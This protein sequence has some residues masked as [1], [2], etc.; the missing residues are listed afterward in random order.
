MI[1]T[2]AR[3]AHRTRVLVKT[4]HHQKGKTMAT[5][6]QERA[7]AIIDEEHFQ[8]IHSQYGGSSFSAALFDCGYQDMP[9]AFSVYAHFKGLVPHDGSNLDNVARVRIGK[10]MEK[11]IAAETTHQKGWELLTGAHYHDIANAHEDRVFVL[12][13]DPALRMGCTVDCYVKEHEDGPG[14]I[15]CKNRDYLQWLD[16]Y[17]DGHASIRDRIQLSHQFLCHPEIKWGCIAALVGG[18]TLEIYTYKPADLA[19]IMAD[20]EAGWRDMW[21]RVDEGDEPTLTGNELPLWLLAHNEALGVSPAVL[22]LDVDA[23]AGDLPFDKAAQTYVEA[24]SLA[25]TYT[26]AAKEMKAVL[27]QSLQEH[28]RARSNRY[29]VVCKY[30]NIDAAIVTLPENIKVGLRAAS[31]VPELMEADQAH[32]EA[33]LDWSQPTRKASTRTTLKFELDPVDPEAQAAMQANANMQ[34]PEAKPTADMKKAHM[35]AQAPL[36]GQN[37]AR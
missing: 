28:G 11:V 34:A 37:K 8:Q 14:I 5:Q 27:I 3:V 1:L 23:M 7:F 9:S 13:P 2:L 12:H 17:I 31:L 25:K 32:I 20:I 4:N 6:Q 24:N 19:D 10:M 30:S 35:D 18:N 29:H 36:P 26:K 21:R 33:A 15:E 22:R 16:G